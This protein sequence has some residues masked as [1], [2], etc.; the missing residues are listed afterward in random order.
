MRLGG[1]VLLSDCSQED[2]TRTRVEEYYRS[3][4]VPVETSSGPGYPMA[5]GLIDSGTS[6]RTSPT[7][8][9]IPIG[10]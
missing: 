1:L 9:L 4:V 7:G 5:V 3:S 6:P 2:E 8:G 10:R